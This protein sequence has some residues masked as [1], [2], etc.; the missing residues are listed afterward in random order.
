MSAST[1]DIP[2]F[3]QAWTRGRAVAFTATRNPALA[4][5]AELL[6][7]VSVGSQPAVTAEAASDL[8][9]VRNTHRMAR[10]FGELVTAF[11][12]GDPSRARNIW[13]TLLELNRPYIESSELGR[14][15]MID[16]ID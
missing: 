10:Y 2:R 12:A 11:A 4:V 3:V 5:I 8:A 6:Q 1:D 9:W 7:W 16:L 15:L 13:D 14:R